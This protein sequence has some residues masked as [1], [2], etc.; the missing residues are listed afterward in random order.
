MKV[1]WPYLRERVCHAVKSEMKGKAM[2]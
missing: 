2:K 1:T